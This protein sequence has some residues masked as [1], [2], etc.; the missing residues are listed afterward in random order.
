MGGRTGA[1][2][3]KDQQPGN[4]KRGIGVQIFA[5]VEQLT[6]NEAMK[7]SAAIAQ[8]AERTGRRPGTVAA[9]YYRIARQRGVLL[10]PRRSTNGRRGPGKEASKTLAIAMR[11]IEAALRAQEGELAMLRKDNQRFAKFA[12]ASRNVATT[13][14]W[15]ENTRRT[16]SMARWFRHCRR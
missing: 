9:N 7:R 11:A 13:D 6:A 10:R 2:R 5:E 1:K 14:P 3:I 8:I 12:A 16:L 15:R 4:R